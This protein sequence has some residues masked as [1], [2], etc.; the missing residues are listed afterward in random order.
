MEHASRRPVA[1][2]R[3]ERGEHHEKPSIAGQAG[4]RFVRR[5]RAQSTLFTTVRPA[6]APEGAENSIGVRTTKPL[7]CLKPEGTRYPAARLFI[8]PISEAA[9][10]GTHS[11]FP[12]HQARRRKPLRPR[13]SP[14]RKPRKSVQ[15]RLGETT[16]TAGQDHRDGGGMPWARHH[17]RQPRAAPGSRRAWP[18]QA[19]FWRR[20]TKAPY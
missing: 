1:A 3:E 12:V 9:K 5:R 18:C 17:T 13:K 20:R 4:G 14:S 19:W 10:D 2:E 7:T 15:H 6:D 16:E 8:I 11:N